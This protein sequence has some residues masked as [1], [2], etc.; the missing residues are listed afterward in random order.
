MGDEKI[1]GFSLNKINII[2]VVLGVILSILLI[3]SLYMITD[4]YHKMNESITEY[5]EWQK[6]ASELENASDYLTE[7]VRCFVIVREKEYVD[8]Y[9]N[10]AYYLKRREK[11]LEHIEER[12]KN[13]D[14][15]II[16]N[17][18][19]D[20]SN[21]L[22]DKEYHAMKLI[23][24]AQGY[25]INLFPDVVKNYNLSDDELNMTVQEKLLCAQNLVFGNEYKNSKL[26]ISTNVRNCIKILEEMM[27]ERITDSS[28][29]LKSNMIF[30]QSII[31]LFLI[32]LIFIF[33][34]NYIKIVGPLKRG[35]IA[36]KEEE[37]LNIE[38]VLEYKS[39]AI[40]YNKIRRND[41]II[42][43]KLMYEAEHDKLTGLYN[44][45]G[46]YRLFKEMNL[47]KVSYILIDVD[48]FK[49]VNDE[50][51]HDVG[52]LVLRKVAEALDLKFR[53]NADVFRI[54][55]D[56][57]AIL[58]NNINDDSIEEIKNKF[59]DIT[60]TLQKKNKGIP[61]VTLS[62]GVAVAEE[63]DNTDSLFKKADK[64][65]YE[66]KNRGRNGITIYKN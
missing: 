65:L 63:N 43:E 54:G 58:L 34:F 42:N 62:V 24:L 40:E 2:Y 44:R 4:K 38:G 64:A 19:L 28:K 56:E 46:Y 11:A 60:N 66:T 23:I 14:A 41:I 17:H 39:F 25:A 37:F 1:K 52:D 57:F 12:L 15:Y 48:E 32:F 27:T 47:A 7:Q 35:V 49:K 51:G 20:E 3:A 31:T 6:D 9:F 29:V 10:E 55:G 26:S 16:L 59:K 45:S 50:F 61:A 33:T 18:A 21:E 36:I 30:Q 22:M 5:V 8:N 53:I 13:T